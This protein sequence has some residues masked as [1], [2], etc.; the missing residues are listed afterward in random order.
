MTIVFL[1]GLI[2]V[3]FIATVIIMSQVGEQLTTPDCADDYIYDTEYVSREDAAGI[4]V[5]V[6]D[7]PNTIYYAPKYDAKVTIG[8]RDGLQWVCTRGV[9]IAGN[10]SRWQCK[11]WVPCAQWD[12]VEGIGGT[13]PPIGGRSIWPVRECPK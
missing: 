8:C 1:R 9:D 2:L 10:R 4:E 5:V 12:L 11:I 7:D 3:S 6:M 13:V